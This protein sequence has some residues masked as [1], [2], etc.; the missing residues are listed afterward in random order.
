VG[1]VIGVLVTIP[2]IVLAVTL[3]GSSLKTRFPCAAGYPDS[4]CG[5]FKAYYKTKT[6]A[7]GELEIEF[8]WN[9]PI[10]P[11]LKDKKEMYNFT[12]LIVLS[13]NNGKTIY[14]IRDEKGSR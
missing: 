5:S 2:V 1:I 4:T 3:T 11:H 8:N 9:I 12:Q 14:A 6:V 10:K 7:S 13:S